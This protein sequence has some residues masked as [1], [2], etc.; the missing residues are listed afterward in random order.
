MVAKLDFFQ[1]GGGIGAD[2]SSLG[3]RPRELQQS[4]NIEVQSWDSDF[5]S[6]RRNNS[7]GKEAN[8]FKVLNFF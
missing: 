6:A 1:S 3:I 7:G 2:S 5:L 4:A 8:G